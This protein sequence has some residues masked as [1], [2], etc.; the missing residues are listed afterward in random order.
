VEVTL[1]SSASVRIAVPSA[2]ALLAPSA[3]D[4]RPLL[5]PGSI[6]ASI[7]GDEIQLGS[8]RGRGPIEIPSGAE[9]LRVDWP[10]GA[11]P[12]AAE[13]RAFRG[14]LVL[15]R[16]ARSL[17]IANRLTLE[18]YLAGVVG[19][20]MPAS[21]SPIEALKAQAVASRTYVL[22]AL[23][24]AAGDGRTA[25]VAGDDSFQVY[26]GK[27]GEHRRVIEAVRATSGE[28]LTYRGGL[29]RSYFHSTCGGHTVDASRVFGEPSIEPLAGVA[30]G[31]C[32]GSA[33]SRW[34]VRVETAA[35]EKALGAWAGERGL[36]LG[37]ITGLE[38]SE[39]TREGRAAYLRVRHAGG[40]FEVGVERFRALLQGTGG[41]AL[42]SAAFTVAPD[43]GAFRVTGTG[44]GHGAGLCQVGAGR[45][46]AG[47]SYRE[48]LELYYPGS[49]V[50]G[51][52]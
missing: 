25:R 50:V 13:A 49:E 29:F 3:I 44:F 48:V 43:G 15:S 33:F 24:R 51:A 10:P 11:A 16:A 2:V 9:P 22:Y 35:L 18:E 28:V 36:K 21:S 12:G 8:W 4:A 40:S 1:A 27:K 20:E 47:R 6:V 46:G 45:L 39:T 14:C 41:P 38:V 7:E 52:Y 19:A 5:P 30:C 42:K 37:T 26:A 23:L 34:E 17:V 31:A 32:E